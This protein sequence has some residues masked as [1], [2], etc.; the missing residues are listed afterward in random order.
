MVGNDPAFSMI[1][2]NG[3]GTPINVVVDPRSM[4]V[5]MRQEGYGGSLYGVLTD[6]AQSNAP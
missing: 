6:L 4:Q 5:V 3:A 1:E 2:G